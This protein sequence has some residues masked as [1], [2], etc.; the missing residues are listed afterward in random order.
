MYNGIYARSLIGDHQ[1][2]AN[3]GGL[4]QAGNSNSARH[5]K[6]REI[7]LVRA[8]NGSVIAT[9]GCPSHPI[10][11]TGGADANHRLSRALSTT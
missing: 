5:G 1:S 10:A 8:S 4:P 7:A 11:S 6:D 9:S 3:Y 2:Q